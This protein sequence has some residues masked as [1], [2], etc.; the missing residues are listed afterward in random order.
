MRGEFIDVGGVRLYYFAA[1]TRGTGEPIVFL[2]GFPTSSHLWTDVIPVA[3]A[4]HRLVVVDLLGYGRSDRP[5]THDVS[6]RA[7]AERTIALLDELS[8]NYACIVGH[9]LGGGIAQAM[10]LRWPARVSR[11]CLVNSVAFDEWP[12]REVR[13][14]RAMLPLTRHLPPQWILSVLRSDLLRGYLASDRGQHSVEMYVRPFASPE[15]RDALVKHLGALDA[16]E[17]RSMAPRLKHI[18]APTAI[19][20]GAEDPF[21]PVEM[22]RRLQ[23]AIPDST[24]DIIPDVRHFTP[25]EAPERIGEVLTKLLAR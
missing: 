19:V 12:G 16:A 6:I 17:T 4:G 7:H 22:S 20:W 2:H 1:G 24:L 21:L 9:D 25:E 15:G 18:V 3:P 23:E 13:L 10:A 11:L 5:G 8:I 14:A